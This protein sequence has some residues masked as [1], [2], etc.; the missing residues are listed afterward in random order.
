MK[1]RLTEIA[2][3]IARLELVLGAAS[4]RLEEG[5]KSPVLPMMPVAIEEGAAVVETALDMIDRLS[6][7]VAA[8]LASEGIEEQA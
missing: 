5:M 3:S 1:Q 8:L 2:G 7:D 4:S 6:R